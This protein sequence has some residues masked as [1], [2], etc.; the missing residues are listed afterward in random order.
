MIQVFFLK[1]YNLL[2]DNFEERLLLILS[3]FSLFQIGFLLFIGLLLSDELFVNP[4]TVY[5]FGRLNDLISA[6]E[7]GPHHL[8][9]KS[10]CFFIHI[11]KHNSIGHIL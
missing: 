7:N 8:I 11:I 3:L 6:P 2:L 9:F 1:L 4:R 10:D 5:S